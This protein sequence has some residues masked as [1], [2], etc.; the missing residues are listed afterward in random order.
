M[1]FIGISAELSWLPIVIDQVFHLL[2]LAVAA[3][4]LVFTSP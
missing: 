2:I 1:R 3:Q 4:V